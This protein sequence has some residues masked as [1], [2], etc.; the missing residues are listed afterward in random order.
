MNCTS[1]N[2]ASAAHLRESVAIL[3]AVVLVAVV[4][5][6]VLLVAVLPVFVPPACV[7]AAA[8]LVGLS[9]ACAIGTCSLQWFCVFSLVIPA[10]V[11]DHPQLFAAK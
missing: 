8:V 5:V 10:C 11:G 1:A 4:L 6:A 7:S 3:V 9:R 2:A